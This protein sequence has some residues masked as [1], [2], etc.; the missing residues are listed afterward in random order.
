MVN[1]K[2]IY[3]SN[4]L[5]RL[6]II[7]IVIIFGFLMM[8]IPIFKSVT[9]SSMIS[10]RFMFFELIILLFLFLPSII[11]CI[12]AIRTKD[13]EYVI[14]PAI[15]LLI[16]EYYFFHDYS[17][18]I[19]SNPNAAIGLVIIPIFLI[20]ILGGSYGVA[21]IFLKIRKHISRRI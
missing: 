1:L 13:M 11:Y 17:T 3:K 14:I 4:N 10:Q 8:A 9:I 6:L 16:A 21:F 2:N 19:S 18:W 5:L 7:A 20:L 12:I 15:F